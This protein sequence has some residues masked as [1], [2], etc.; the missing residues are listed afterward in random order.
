MPCDGFLASER[1]RNEPRP[2]LASQ[3]QLTRRTPSGDGLLV[4]REEGAFAHRL[5]GLTSRVVSVVSR[6]SAFFNSHGTG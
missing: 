1:E 3:L 6:E 5:S 2:F 4:F